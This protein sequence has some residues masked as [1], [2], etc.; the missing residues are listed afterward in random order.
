MTDLTLYE[1]SEF[2]EEEIKSRLLQESK[3]ILYKKGRK[4]FKSRDPKKNTNKK[5][6]VCRDL[7][8]FI[9][10]QLK[11]ILSCSRFLSGRNYN[12]P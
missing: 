2:N 4:G 8:L 6:A 9:K 11:S 1:Y 7:K 5:E 12:N 10:G 3:V